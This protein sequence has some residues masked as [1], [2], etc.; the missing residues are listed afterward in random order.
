[1]IAEPRETLRGLIIETR[2]RGYHFRS[3][4]EARW[5]VFFE[6]LAL[7]AE[8]EPQGFVTS[9]GAYLPDFFVNEWRM[10]VE[11]KPWLAQTELSAHCAKIRAVEKATSQCALVVYG[12]PD[13]IRGAMIFTSQGQMVASHFDHGGPRNTAP[14]DAHSIEAYTRA[15]SERFEKR[16]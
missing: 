7:R 15:Q 5:Y 14:E 9:S 11:I 13:L 16:A 8:Y 12:P 1:M 2:F 6:A 4:L 10:W 3:R